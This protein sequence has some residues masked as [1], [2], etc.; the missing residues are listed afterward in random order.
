MRSRCDAGRDAAVTCNNKLIGA[1]YYDRG[2]LN[3]HRPAS[4]TRRVTSTATAR[5][6]RA[7]PPATTASTPS[8]TADSVGVTGMAPAARARGVQGLLGR[9]ADRRRQL[10]HRR[11]RRRDRRRGRR[12]RRRHQLLDRRLPDSDRRPGRARVPQRR[13]AGVFVAASAGNTARPRHGGA[14]LAV[15]DHGRREH[16]RPRLRQDG[17]ARQRRH[18][19]GRRRRPGRAR[20][21]R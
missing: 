5:T 15:A 11:H 16:P 1:R 14:Q 19:R 18:L 9:A 2:G 7:R 6:P 12:R 21:R 8:S 10:R 3:D 17:D 4:S 13:R 20:R